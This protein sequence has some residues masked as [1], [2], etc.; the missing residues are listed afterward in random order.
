V[1]RQI[2]QTLNKLIPNRTDELLK[3][4]YTRERERERERKRVCLTEKFSMKSK[5]LEL[6]RMLRKAQ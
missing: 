4:C 3:M 2:L 6:A 5:K 1:Y